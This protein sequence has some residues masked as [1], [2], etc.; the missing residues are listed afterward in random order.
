[1]AQMVLLGDEAVAMG[2]IDAGVSIAYGYPGTPSTEIM[3][4]IQEYA[5]KHNKPYAKWCSNEKTAYEAAVGVS[6]AGKRSIIT[7]KHVG[8]N[9]AADAYLNSVLFNIQGGIVLAV[10]DD[11]GMH[12]SQSEQDSRYFNDFAKAICL[13]PRNQ[14]EAYEM[15]KDAFD[16]SEKFQVPVMIKLVTRLSHS[17]AVVNTGSVREENPLHKDPNR[18]GWFTLPN[19][20]RKQYAKLLNDQKDFLNYTENSP[21]NPLTINK[22]FKDFGVI[23]TGIARN[24]YEENFDDFD[25]LPSHLH[26]SAYPMP[27][28]KIRKL[29]E[30]VNRIVV[31]EEGYSY[32]E[33]LLRGILPGNLPIDGKENSAVPPYGEL[34][35]DNIR[36]ALG[37]PEIKGQNLSDLKLPGRPPQLCV[38]C[39]HIDTYTAIN[40]AVRD[41]DESLVTSDI[42]CY[43]LGYF[44]PYNT[45]ESCLCMGASITMAKGA[46]DAGL[47]PV[48]ATIGD[49]TFM[50]SGITGLVDALST[51]TNMIIVIMDNST[52]AM[53]GGQ[54]TV[55]SSSRIHE[56][57]LGTGIDPEHVHVIEPLKKNHEKNVEI[58]KKEIAYKGVSVIIP[59]RECI[60]TL[61]RK[62]TKGGSK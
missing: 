5:D 54:D 51:N 11:P 23:T 38:G 21:Y 10:A 56:V 55:F 50:H 6:L 13:E 16:L 43:T 20:A 32:V 2:A 22:N 36:Q 8:L 61:R 3:E 48:L 52:T 12:S 58:F 46:A 30:N 15:T 45:I 18:D 53:T 35:P 57:V 7:M 47:F 42:G 40:E 31:L 44:P 41:F 25:Q 1:M 24:Y 37:L 28:E 27:V 14:Q 49:S 33:R 59:L 17:R 19:I 62:N 60:Q 26:I 39:S 34:N 9:V 4:Y 29:A